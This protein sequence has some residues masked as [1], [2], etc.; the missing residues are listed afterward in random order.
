MPMGDAPYF[1]YS[2][3]PAQVLNYGDVVYHDDFV[4]A[5]AETGLTCWNSK[6]GQ[7]VFMN[8]AGF[9]AF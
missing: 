9:E 4:C 1:E 6:T 5:S 3:V 7:G 8:K 2:D